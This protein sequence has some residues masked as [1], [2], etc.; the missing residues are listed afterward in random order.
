MKAL[1][2]I[3]SIAIIIIAYAAPSR[4]QKGAGGSQTSVSGKQCAQFAMARGERLGRPGYTK[5]LRQCKAGKI[6]L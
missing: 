1:A 3:A 5:F 2:S 6:P 4:A